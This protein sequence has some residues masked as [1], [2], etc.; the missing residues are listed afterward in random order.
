MTAPLIWL[1]VGLALIASELLVLPGLVAG[2]VGLAAAIAGLVALVAPIPVQWLVWLGLSVIF[3]LLSRRLVP[4]ESR[5]LQESR[6]AYALSPI[7]AGKKGRVRYAGS[8]WNA[9]C[10]VED[11]EIAAG[12]DLYVL[13]RQGNTLIVMPARLV[14]DP[15]SRAELNHSN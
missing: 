12:Q 3:I 1:V 13:E 15:G 2:S 7:P 6:E 14:K 10:E 8:I 9:R 4:K 5:A 11:L